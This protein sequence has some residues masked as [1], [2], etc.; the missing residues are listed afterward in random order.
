M[1]SIE[2]QGNNRWKLICTFLFFFHS[3]A[4]LR[5][6]GKTHYTSQLTNIVARSKPVKCFPRSKTYSANNQKLQVLH[7]PHNLSFAPCCCCCQHPI[8]S[9]YDSRYYSCYSPP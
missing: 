4:A 6:K 9:G 3:S 7:F 1:L 2:V 5:E 8:D